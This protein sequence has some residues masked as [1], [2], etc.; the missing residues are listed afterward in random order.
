[1]Y[2]CIDALYKVTD[3]ATHNTS[4]ATPYCRPFHGKSQCPLTAP[5]AE[6]V[7]LTWGL[8]TPLLYSGKIFDRENIDEFDKLKTILKFHLLLQQLLHAWLILVIKYFLCIQFIKI[9]CYIAI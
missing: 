6:N 3:F 2:T 7:V 9:F 8:A 1:M 5:E 4:L